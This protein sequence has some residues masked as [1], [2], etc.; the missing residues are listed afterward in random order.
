MLR[1]V[2][3]Y[4]IRVLVLAAAVLA[5]TNCLSQEDADTTEV[6]AYSLTEAGFSK[7]RQATQKLQALPD[8]MSGN[9]DTDLGSMSIDESA[10]M[11]NTIPGAA[12]AIQSAG[13]TTREYVVFSW[14]LI[15]NALAAWV[16]G[17]PGGS[18]PAG[19]SQAN[20]DFVRSHEA[21]LQELNTS[22]QGDGCEDEEE[23]EFGEDDYE[24]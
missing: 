22:Q 3:P 24:E 13:M 12:A 11:F 20:V 17:Q 10:A 4:P 15:H 21:E 19:A 7:Y 14:A 16:A 8:G 18:L 6:M 23:M 9:C 5:W 2:S 1:S